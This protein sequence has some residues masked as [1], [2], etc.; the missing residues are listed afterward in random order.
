MS[1]DDIV[2]FRPGSGIAHRP[3]WGAAAS[4]DWDETEW[5]AFG[6]EDGPYMGGSWTGQPGTLLCNPY[7]YD[8][9]CIMI[10]GRVALIDTEGQRREFSAGDAFFVPKS[11]TGTWETLVPSEKYFIALIGSQAAAKTSG[12]ARQESRIT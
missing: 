10:S 9:V 3:D 1:V 7:P 2:A 12:S 11:F 8:E 6:S 4:P 5:R